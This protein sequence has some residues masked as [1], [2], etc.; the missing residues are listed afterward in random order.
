M[1]SI[2]SGVKTN[3]TSDETSRPERDLDHSYLYITSTFLFP[4]GSSWSSGPSI[5]C[6]KW[7]GK[8]IHSIPF[9]SQKLSV[10]LRKTK[11]NMHCVLSRRVGVLHANALER[12]NI[13][14]P[15]S[16]PP[17]PQARGGFLPLIPDL[18]N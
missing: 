8:T 2:T 9:N 5:F 17:N 16:H 3:T 7:L 10:C 11:S 13:P 14:M 15:G 1:I 6:A 4:P 18:L 12:V